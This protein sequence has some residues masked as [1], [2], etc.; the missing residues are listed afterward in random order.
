MKISKIRVEKFKDIIPIKEK[1][2]KRTH[3]ENQDVYFKRKKST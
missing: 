2:K 3:W 1:L